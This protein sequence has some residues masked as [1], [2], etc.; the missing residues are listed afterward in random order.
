MNVVGRSPRLRRP[1][2]R[3]GL[4]TWR[5]DWRLGFEVGLDVST[6]GFEVFQNFVVGK[7]QNLNTQALEN[8]GAFGVSSQSF[9]CV[10]LG[11]IK[12][13][14]KLISR[15]IKIGNKSSNR[16]LPQP[17]NGLLSQKSEPKFFLCL[18]HLLTQFSSPSRQILV[19]RRPLKHFITVRFNPTNPHPKPPLRGGR[20]SRGESSERTLC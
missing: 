11:A 17:T 5:S 18:R 1:P 2:L 9:W 10:V 8:R 19:V 12:F 3:R 20:R 16:P 7:P 4:G 6:N 15:A 13:D 14:H